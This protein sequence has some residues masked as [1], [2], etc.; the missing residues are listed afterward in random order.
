MPANPIARSSLLLSLLLIA[1]CG[2][3][4]PAPGA[5]ANG[6]R[7]HIVAI[8]RSTTAIAGEPLLEPKTVTRFYRSRQFKT[9]WDLRRAGEILEAIRG[10]VAD[11]LN[12]DD[13]H[14]AAIEKLTHEG[15]ATNA[16]SAAD[17]DVLLSDAVAAIADHV[18]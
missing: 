2:S 10:V 8:D 16:E 11:G 14:R 18:H 15:T 17:L 9:A 12:P 7:H 6:I 4:G 3:H 13:Y 5:V 1:G